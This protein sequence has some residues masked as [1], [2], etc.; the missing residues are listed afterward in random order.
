MQRRHCVIL[1][2]IQMDTYQIEGSGPTPARQ[3]EAS[4]PAA[5]ESPVTQTHRG[6]AV[7]RMQDLVINIK[8]VTHVNAEFS[9]YILLGKKSPNCL[10]K[11][12]GL[13]DM[14]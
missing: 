9:F 10:K 4:S 14:E 7:S 1:P 5:E 2:D 13:G 3:V 11:Y 6:T 8:L 12:Q